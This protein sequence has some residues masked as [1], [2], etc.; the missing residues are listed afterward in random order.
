MKK[1]LDDNK[2]GN[3][4]CLYK[5]CLAVINYGGLFTDSLVYMNEEVKMNY[6]VK[7]TV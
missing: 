3:L 1:V 4:E 6:R 7:I 5:A 2:W